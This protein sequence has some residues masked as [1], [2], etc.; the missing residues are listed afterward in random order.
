MFVGY[1][2]FFDF[3]LLSKQNNGSKNVIQ[4]SDILFRFMTNLV[5]H[6]SLVSA[7]TLVE[8]VAYG[9][10]WATHLFPWFQL[11]PYS[12]KIFKLVLIAGNM[13][14]PVALL[15]FLMSSETSIHS[16]HG[17]AVLIQMTVYRGIY[18]NSTYYV[19]SKFFGIASDYEQKIIKVWGK[20]TLYVV[21][22]V[23]IICL[24]NPNREV[25]L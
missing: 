14:P 17:L 13:A 24:A 8:R 2:F 4:S 22:I 9:V 23:A 16:L 25:S 6:H 7:T 19:F 20:R 1:G 12:Q 21:T 5:H 11:V 3:F 10:C 15:W 18:I